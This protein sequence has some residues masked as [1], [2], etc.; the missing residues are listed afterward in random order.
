MMKQHQQWQ[1]QP[2]GATVASAEKNFSST[3]S[4]DFS[5]IHLLSSGL[6]I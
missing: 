2:P 5:M 4:I 6:K 1:H 3:F